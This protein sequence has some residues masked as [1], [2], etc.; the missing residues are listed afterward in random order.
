MGLIKNLLFTFSR[1]QY[2]PLLKNQSIF[3]YYH[4]VNNNTPAH[5]KHLYPFKSINQF[6]KDLDLLLQH[7]KPLHPESLIHSEGKNIPKNHFLLTFDDGLREVYDVIFPILKRKGISAIFFLN[8]NF[9]DNTNSLYKHDLSVIIE[10][11][12]T[13]TH[14]ENTLK[15]VA[16][17][18][19]SKNTSITALTASIK[20]IKQS[21]STLIKALATTVAVNLQEYLTQKKP[22]LTKH[23]IN[24]MI[25]AGFYFGGHTM[26]HPR[27]LELPLEKQKNEVIN[28]IKWV[29]S[30]FNLDYTAFAF[31]FSDKNISKT[32]INSILE[33]NNK[34]LIFGNAGIKKDISSN[35]IQRFSLEHPNKDTAK[36]IVTENLYKSYNKI[37]GKHTIKRP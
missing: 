33:F 5:I 21:Q 9:I 1:K 23:Q 14:N 3:P 26:S 6:E 12:K 19:N 22:Y 36:R 32:L 27:L 35:I 15:E 37:I 13:K 2:L 18:V 17:L 29:K 8:P 31:P 34:T 7:Y 20:S 25:A 30:T 28:S 10:T 4:I 11:L 16:K 24:E